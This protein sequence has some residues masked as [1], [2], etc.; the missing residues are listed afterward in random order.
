MGRVGLPIHIRLVK[1]G[2]VPYRDNLNRAIE[3]IVPAWKKTKKGDRK[4]QLLLA[5][6]GT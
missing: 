5:A 2:N 4:K 6:S 3:Q 1:D